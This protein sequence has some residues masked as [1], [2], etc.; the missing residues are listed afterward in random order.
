[1]S[2]DD[3]S[4]HK[5]LREAPYF[6]SATTRNFDP[7]IVFVEIYVLK[8]IRLA[9]QTER[10]RRSAHHECSNIFLTKDRDICL[11]DSHNRG[12]LAATALDLVIAVDFRCNSRNCSL[13]SSVEKYFQLHIYLKRLN[14]AYTKSKAIANEEMYK[15]SQEFHNRL[16]QHNS[17]LQSNLETTNEAHKRLETEKSGIVEHLST[18]RGHNKALQEQLASLK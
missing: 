13:S 14:N 10:S 4:S 7:M 9:R 1:M 17:C 11:G 15:T 6:N 18:V 3:S 5:A 2:G 12:V 8:K 16:L